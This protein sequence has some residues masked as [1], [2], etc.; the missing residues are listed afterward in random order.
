M[1]TG[2]PQDF[3]GS[4]TSSRSVTLTWDPPNPEDVNGVV[5]QYIINVTAV[6]TSE[7]FQLTSNTTTLRVT[8]L[9]PFTTFRCIIAAQTTAG[10]GPFSTVF[11]IVTPEDGETTLYVNLLDLNSQ[12]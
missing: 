9:R 1:P 6:E 2:Y 4:A 7:L 11:T 5:V 3:T 10:T 12:L 8:S